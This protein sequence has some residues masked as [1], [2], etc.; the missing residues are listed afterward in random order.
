M[1]EMFWLHQYAIYLNNQIW[2]LREF[3]KLENIR[4]EQAEDIIAC[5]PKSKIAL[6]FANSQQVN[7]SLTN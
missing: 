4:L 5:L 2:S 6:E 1:K 7:L 3:G